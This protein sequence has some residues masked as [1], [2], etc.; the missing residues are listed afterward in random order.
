MQYLEGVAGLGL[1]QEATEEG[2]VGP[3][4]VRYFLQNS[5]TGSFTLWVRNT[6]AI[7]SDG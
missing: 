3:C 1:T 6:G 5:G 7:G 4:D 2:G